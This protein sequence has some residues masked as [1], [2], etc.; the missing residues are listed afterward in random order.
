VTALQESWSQWL[1]QRPWDLFL[2]LT[3]EIRTHPEALQKRFGY[4]V[5][6]MSDALYGRT[7][8]RERCPIEFVNGI[9][10]HKSGWPH[11]HGLLRIPGVD[12]RDR[13]QFSLADWQ[14]RITDTGGYAWLSAPRNQADVVSYVTKYVVKDGEL[15]LS[16]N[17]SPGVDPNPPLPLVERL[18]GEGAVRARSRV[19]LSRLS[20][21][22]MTVLV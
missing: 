21:A 3:S 19:T 6:Q 13:E 8:T 10:R 7:R 14:Q 16:G 1:S 12:M 18:H 20:A 5:H 11:S 2:T 22:A 4:C 17:L 9:E 15:V